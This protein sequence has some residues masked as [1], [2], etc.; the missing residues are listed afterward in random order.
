MSNRVPA[1][2][3]EFTWIS[4][5]ALSAGRLFIGDQENHRVSVLDL[6]SGEVS[7]VTGTGTEGSGGDGGP[8]VQ[9]RVNRPKGLVVH[10]NIL[11][12]ADAGDDRIRAV[13]LSSGIITTVVGTGDEGSDDL[14]G[15]VSPRRSIRCS[16]SRR[17]PRTCSS[18]SLASARF[19]LSSS[20]PGGSVPSLL[21]DDL[22]ATNRII[23]MTW[24]DGLSLA[25]PGAR[26][27][28]KGPVLAQFLHM[29]AD[30]FHQ[31]HTCGILHHNLKP[32][33]ILVGRNGTAHVVDFGISWLSDATRLTA[34]SFGMLAYE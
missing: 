32:G 2:E 18:L 25:Q 19:A 22:S 6:D 3:A 31:L 14:A 8:A 13:D 20:Q 11:Y 21:Y 5:L 9:A 4:S 17:T 30:T 23:V 16:R 1:D 7:I 29:L 12:I 24:V 10:E 33:N 34:S 27:P 28:L 26:T 15:E